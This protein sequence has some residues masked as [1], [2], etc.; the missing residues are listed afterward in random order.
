MADQKLSIELFGK[1]T[2]LRDLRN[3]WDGLL[4]GNFRRARVRLVELKREH[5]R[6]KVSYRVMRGRYGAA[7]APPATPDQQTTKSN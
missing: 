5:M 6:N 1:G 4:Y 2:K 7:S 3:G